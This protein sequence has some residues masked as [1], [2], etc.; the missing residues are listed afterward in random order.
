[1]SMCFSLWV[2]SPRNLT[3]LKLDVRSSVLTSNNQ[4]E[5]GTW[6]REK[7]QREENL[8]F[9]YKDQGHLNK[10]TFSQSDHAFISDVLIS[11]PL[12]NLLGHNSLGGQEIMS[13]KQVEM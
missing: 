9:F 2:Q 11:Q 4:T 8:I 3:H 5:K 12:F 7:R 1:M 13:A 10:A 6:D